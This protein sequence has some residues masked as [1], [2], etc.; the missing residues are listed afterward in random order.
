MARRRSAVAILLFALLGVLSL[1]TITAADEVRRGCARAACAAG[2]RRFER[3][4]TRFATPHRRSFGRAFVRAAASQTG[5][6]GNRKARA[7]RLRRCWCS[8]ECPRQ[9]KQRAAVAF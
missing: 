3:G 6:V 8:L 9:M 2:C 4:L 7:R 1:T 5:S